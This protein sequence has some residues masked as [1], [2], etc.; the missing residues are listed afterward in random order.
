MSSFQ[1]F[2]YD[3]LSLNISFENISSSYFSLIIKDIYWREI[4]WE[5]ND[6]ERALSVTKAID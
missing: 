1:G 6:Y 5:T 3:A 4:S 2:E